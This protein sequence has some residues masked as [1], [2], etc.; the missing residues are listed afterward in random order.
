MVHKDKEK[1]AKLVFTADSIENNKGWSLVQRENPLLCDYC[2]SP[3]FYIDIVWGVVEE[4]HLLGIKVVN[5]DHKYHYFLREVGFN[6]YCAECGHFHEHY[7]KYFYPEDK[8]VCYWNDEELDY[9]EKEEIWYCLSQFNQKG[10]FIPRY[11]SSEMKY[12]K[13]KLEE[14]KLNLTKLKH[15]VR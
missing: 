7:D 8:V 6:L 11:K 5:E 1:I 13:I 4:V 14:Y 2:K 10:D 9:A 12:L 3:L 15:K